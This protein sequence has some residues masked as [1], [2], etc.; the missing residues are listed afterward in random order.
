VAN[1]RT[2]GFSLGRGQRLGITTALLGDPATLLLDEPVNGL[3][4]EG[5][6]QCGIA[7]GHV[8]VEADDHHPSP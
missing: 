7:A 1:R 6:R 2:G 5:I 4:P 8:G 3:D